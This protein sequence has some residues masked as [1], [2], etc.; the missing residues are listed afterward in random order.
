MLWS[1]NWEYVIH[2]RVKRLYHRAIELLACELVVR[3]LSLQSIVRKHG[4]GRTPTILQSRFC[5]TG[6][7]RGE[8]TGHQW[9]T[10]PLLGEST[11]HR[12]IPLTK[13][14]Y[15]Q[16]WCFLWSAPEQTVKQPDDLRR[17]RG[18]YDVTVMI[19]GYI[20]I[21]IWWYFIQCVTPSLHRRHD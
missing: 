8:S 14:S 7:L 13:D 16:V 2:P 4:L 10:V 9:I 3:F 6:H 1:I 11:V 15:A 21:L 12:W 17:H 19:A 20:T 5:V 18:H